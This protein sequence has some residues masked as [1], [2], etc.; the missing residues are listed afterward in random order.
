MNPVVHFE[1][2]SEDGKRMS[3]FYTKVFDWQTQPMG[4]ESGNYIMVAT[5]KS[6]KNGRP[7]KPGA[8][9]GGFFP[10]AKDN[11]SKYPSVV[12]G[13]DNIEEHIK[14]VIEAGGKVLADPVDIPK[15]GKYV[16]FIDT[17]GNLVSMLQP[18]DV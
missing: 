7:K 10:K 13:V 17:E 18:S 2:P 3:N 6:D 14:K 5:T 12:I 11:P 8:I 16:S 9:N 4:P 1:M 15:V